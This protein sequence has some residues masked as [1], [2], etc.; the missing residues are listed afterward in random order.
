MGLFPAN[1]VTSSTR[2]QRERGM[3]D[4]GTFSRC[5]ETRAHALRTLK[6]HLSLRQRYVSA[7]SGAESSLRALLGAPSSTWKPIQVSNTYRSPEEE[8]SRTI[9]AST[10]ST[11]VASRIEG[12]VIL[13]R[14]KAKNAP[15][16][17]RAICHV[18]VTDNAAALESFRAVLQNTEIRPSWD[19]VT[20]REELLEIVE[21][22]ITVSRSYTKVGWPGK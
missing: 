22:G 18:P 12:P 17:I 14:K 3:A 4:G 19:S 5:I 16:V 13:H 11:C 7:L 21:P 15:D 2:P 8:V 6:S 1:T 20:E 10:S 9:E